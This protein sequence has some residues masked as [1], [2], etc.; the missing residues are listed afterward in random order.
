MKTMITVTR[1][2]LLASLCLVAAPASAQLEVD[3]AEVWRRG[4]SIEYIQGWNGPPA[5]RHEITGSHA[6][7]EK[8]FISVLVRKDDPRC[9]ALLEDWRDSPA[10]KGFADPDAPAKS[11]AHFRVYDVDDRSQAFRWK[12]IRIG[13]V[14]TVIVQP[15]L[16]G[17]WGKPSTV[18]CQAI[19]RDDP[20]RLANDLAYALQLYASKLER[21]RH[22][23]PVN[24]N[25]YRP[26]P[27]Q[28]W[29]PVG[30]IGAPL[31]SNEP[32]P[33]GQRPIG[34]SPSPWD[35]PRRV[36]PLELP[37]RFAGD[38]D[39]GQCPGPGPCPNPR[40]N[41][42][43][44]DDGYTPGPWDDSPYVRPRPPRP[45]R[46]EYPPRPSP[47]RPQSTEGWL[48][49]ILG[50]VVVLGLGWT[51]AQGLFGGMLARIDAAL[52]AAVNRKLSESPQRP[53][54]E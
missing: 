12:E 1:L 49:W 28:P 36:P 10:L 26:R 44:D 18:I 46:D 6:D 39:L 22:G 4:D 38:D 9:A 42:R 33:P 3:A 45:D 25:P 13:A 51:F 23:P 34:Q 54:E 16:S 5:L 17:A 15:C 53:P 32:P 24:R 19:Y 21:P 14:P 11:W 31:Y 50:G 52:S 27:G 47:L 8:F 37:P 48:T 40:P 43:P 41:P 35:D 2:A 29:E 20:Q 30:A 7:A